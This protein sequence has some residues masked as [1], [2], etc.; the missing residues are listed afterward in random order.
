M[1]LNGGGGFPHNGKNPL[2][3]INLLRSQC[4]NKLPHFNIRKCPWIQRR[5]LGL[6]GIF[7]IALKPTASCDNEVLR[8]NGDGVIMLP[9]KCKTIIKGSLAGLN[10]SK[11]GMWHFHYI[12]TH[13]Q[14]CQKEQMSDRWV[15]DMILRQLLCD[16]ASFFA[17]RKHFL[18]GKVQTQYIQLLII[19]AP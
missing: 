6:G 12:G 10:L 18:D 5:I 19:R 1:L 9:I 2:I 16:W 3:G 13:D 17:L 4:Q 8:R 11:L 14:V 15:T 7:S